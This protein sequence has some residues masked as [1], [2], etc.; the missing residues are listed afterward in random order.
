MK[1]IVLR[2]GVVR[3]D[4]YLVKSLLECFTQRTLIDKT[5]CEDRIVYIF[6]EAYK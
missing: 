2:P 5:V 6:S 1:I 3:G 4:D